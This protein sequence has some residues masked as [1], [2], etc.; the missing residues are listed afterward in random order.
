MRIALPSSQIKKS[1]SFGSTVHLTI[2]DCAG[3]T[4][5]IDDIYVSDFSLNEARKWL[6]EIDKIPV[7]SDSVWATF[8]IREDIFQ[9]E[10]SICGSVSGGGMAEGKTGGIQFVVK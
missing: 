1:A 10:D 2:S 7:G 5:S 3:A 9:R 6:P 8:Y 4:L